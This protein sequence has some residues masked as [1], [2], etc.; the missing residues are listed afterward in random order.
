MKTQGSCKIGGQCIAHM[1]VCKSMEV[2]NEFREEIPVAY[3]ISNREDEHVLRQYFEELKKCVDIIE[4]Q[5][6]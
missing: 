3:T 2:Y 4:P 5:F 1:K 6:F